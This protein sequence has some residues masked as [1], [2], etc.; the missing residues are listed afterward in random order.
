MKRDLHAEQQF[1]DSLAQSTAS[2][3]GNMQDCL[4]WF[5]KQG[6]G[7]FIHLSCDVQLGTVISHNLINENDDYCQRYFTELP[8]TFNPNHFDAPSWARFFRTIGMKYVILTN[9]HHNGFSEN[10]N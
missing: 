8:Q 6:V 3:L 10:F 2:G 9:K 1:Q 7:A 5:Q 4:T